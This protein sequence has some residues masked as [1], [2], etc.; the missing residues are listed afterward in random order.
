M[1]LSAPA[2]INLWLSILGKR[3]DHFHEIETLM[4]PVSL[5]DHLT[6]EKSAE[7]IRFFCDD[8][9]L[10]CDERNLA[11]KAAGLFFKKA[12]MTPAVEIRLRKVIPHGAGLGGG[13][14]DAANVLLGLNE[15]CGT[16]LDLNALSAMASE[17][18]SDVPF[19]LW[20]TA[21]ICRGRG[22]RVQ[23]VEF[24]QELPLLLV[25]PPFGVPTPWAY[26]RWSDSKQIPG[27]LYAAQDFPWGKLQNDLERPVFEKHFVLAQLKSW[28]LQQPEVSGALMS[29]S[30]STCF[31]VLKE[32]GV[33]ATL[34]ERVRSEFGQDFWCTECQTVV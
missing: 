16:G 10:P 31:A 27:V 34:A 12:A 11:V 13:S 19:F 23:P 2:K 28:F 6:L 32:S 24:K 18:G 21:A 1:E 33:G 5:A 9:S 29:G 8:Q 20:R 7:G 30:G 26:Q 25:K 17:I 14:S 3:P 22:E 4:V 15:L